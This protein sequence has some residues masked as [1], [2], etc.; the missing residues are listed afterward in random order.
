VMIHEIIVTN[1]SGERLP[2]T[3][4][5][6]E[7][8]GLIIVDVQGLGPAKSNINVRENATISGSIF[9]SAKTPS[10]NIVL[11]LQF[12]EMYDSAGMMV[13]TIEQ[14]RL[15]TYRYF[16]TESQIRLDV[17][18][19]EG[20]FYI[21]GYVESNEA[22]IFSIRSGCVIS[23]LCP[24]PFF[25]SDTGYRED[26]INPIGRLFEFPFSSEIQE[27]SAFPG[28]IPSSPTSYL[29]PEITST[30]NYV[31]WGIRYTPDVSITTNLLYVHIESMNGSL[32]NH[33]V[34]GLGVGDILVGTEQTQS[35][36]MYAPHQLTTGINELQFVDPSTGNPKQFSFVAG[37]IYRI[38][39]YATTRDASPANCSLSI[40][41]GNDADPANLALLSYSGAGFTGGS[42]ISGHK[43]MFGLGSITPSESDIAGLIVFGEHVFDSPDFTIPFD[44]TIPV[45]PTLKIQASGGAIE[46]PS[47]FFYNVNDPTDVDHLKFIFSESLPKLEDGDYLLI[48]CERQNKSVTRYRS[49]DGELLNYIGAVSL[50]SAWPLLRQGE[51]K[52]SYT[53]VTGSEYIRFSYEYL[54]QFAGV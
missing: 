28:Y 37:T 54:L 10:R 38:L 31:T 50:D 51:N 1:P 4:M 6:P 53:A 42:V 5:R 13:S 47:I 26:I 35:Q 41:T 33:N 32:Y 23:I 20:T 44:G 39:L 15:R 18:T 12:S 49:S 19:D 45:G 24:D 7:S 27:A 29:L 43:P 11:T 52:F 17:R 21:Y 9:N 36:T 16:P 25:R 48:S 8:S 30:N 34:G 2:L 14:T 3:L 40:R 46:D 22:T